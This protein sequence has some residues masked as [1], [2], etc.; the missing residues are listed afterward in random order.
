MK[1]VSDNAKHLHKKGQCA[2]SAGVG[3]GVWKNSPTPVTDERKFSV[4]QRQGWVI[5]KVSGA[6]S[7]AITKFTN[8]PGTTI[9]FL[10]SLPSI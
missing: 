2:W 7:Q 8:F 1:K 10:I 6:G 9:T 5:P 3:C 4:I